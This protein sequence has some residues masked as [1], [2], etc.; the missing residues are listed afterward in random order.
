M[1]GLNSF[2]AL[3]HFADLPENE[4]NNPLQIGKKIDILRSDSTSWGD[5]EIVIIG[6]G[7][8]RGNDANHSISYAPDAIRA[9]LYQLYNWHKEVIIADAGNLIQGAT[10][11]DSRAALATVLHELH[12]AGK[13]VILLGGSQDLTLQQYDAFRK[14]NETIDAAII[15]MLID[16][17]ETET[18]DDTGYLMDML[19]T[20]PNFVKN[21]THIGFQSY[22]VNPNLL[23]TLN[24]LR[25]DCYRLGH[26][27]EN[28]EEVEPALRQCNLLSVDMKAMKYSDALFLNEASPNGFNGDE[29]CQLIRYA[30]MSSHLSSL[31]IYGYLPEND[32]N[33]I[34]AKQIA[35]MIWYFIDGYAMRKKEASLNQLEEFLVYDLA[36]TGH[37][38]KFLK[39]KR[40]NRW[41]MQMPDGGYIPCSYSDYLIASQDEMPERWLRE[42]ERIV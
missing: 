15:D 3:Q 26:V 25:F 34:G 24:K 13:V 38:S 41:W 30:G 31:G 9:A 22:Y 11:A 1:H 27:R 37:K 33:N 28:M 42:Q 23:D 35:Q 16:L 39:S 32:A 2:F 21:F 18:I 8:Q 36:F 12:Q 19:T 29:M 5:A 40:T 7:E 4:S 14:E 10:L 20:Q 17:N 6:C